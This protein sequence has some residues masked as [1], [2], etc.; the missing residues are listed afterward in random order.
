MFR[1]SVALSLLVLAGC[2]SVGDPPQQ[3]ASRDCKI[4]P[5]EPTRTYGGGR[6]RASE[7]EQR[8]AVGA[9]GSSD[10]RFRE[11]NKPFGLN[12]TI[13]ESLRDCNR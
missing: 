11:L 10:L 9:L 12:G 2:A 6:P 3:V 1:T 5:L 4:Y 13:E 7:L 8:W